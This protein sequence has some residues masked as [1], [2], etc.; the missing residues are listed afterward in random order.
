MRVLTLPDEQAVARAAADRLAESLARRP[1]LVLGL[2]T[3]RT[4]IPFYDELARRHADGTLDLSR[5]HAFNLDEL[6]LPRGHAATFKTFMERHAWGRAGFDRARCAILDSSPEDPQGEC[7]RYDAA[8]AAAGGLDFVLL[9]VGAD[10]HVAYNLPGEPVAATHLVTLPEA[11][12]DSLAVP[13][14]YR[15][16]RAM[17]LGL[18]A[19]RGARRVVV[20]ATTG[21]KA[22]A[23]RALASGRPDPAWPCS[24][25]A[26]HPDLELLLTPVAA[27]ELA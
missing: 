19:L 25:L 17:T 11:L 12:A 18:G 20:A 21:E 13:G 2:P 26:E 3:G 1:D 24:L 14:S 9:G 4:A 23:V 16:L 5:A 8:L 10:G 22:R 6:L 7:R 15:P 27:A